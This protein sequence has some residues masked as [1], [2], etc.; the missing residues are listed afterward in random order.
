[1]HTMCYGYGLGG[2]LVITLVVRQPHVHQ[3]L[4]VQIG[5]H[6]MNPP[7]V[8]DMLEIVGGKATSASVYERAQ[9]LALHLNKTVC[10]S[11]DRPVCAARVQGW[12]CLVLQISLWLTRAK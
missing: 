3:V 9:V 5:M 2:N 8:T 1:M 6:F 11:S 7:V 10:F 4:V 12:L